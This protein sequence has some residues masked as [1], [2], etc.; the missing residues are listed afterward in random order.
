MTYSVPVG[1]PKGTVSV[2]PEGMPPV[3]VELKVD[4]DPATQLI[5][6]AEVLRQ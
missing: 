1:V 5:D 6:V 2:V 4:L 3:G